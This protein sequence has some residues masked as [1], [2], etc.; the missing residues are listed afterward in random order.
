[1]ATITK[2]DNYSF[3]HC[4]KFVDYTNKTEGTILM[5]GN[6]SIEGFDCGKI[7]KSIYMVEGNYAYGKNG[8][9][10]ELLNMQEDYQQFI[11]AF[12]KT[13][14]QMVP[15]SHIYGN[16]RNGYFLRVGAGFTR[17]I[18]S[19]DRNILTTEGGYEYFVYW[20]C[21]Y[22][23]KEKKVSNGKMQKYWLEIKYPEEFEKIDDERM[24]PILFKDI[25]ASETV[26]FA[27]KV[28]KH[29]KKIFER[30]YETFYKKF[31]FKNKYFEEYK[32][33]PLV[34]KGK[35]LK[36]VFL[37]VKLESVYFKESGF[38]TKCNF[39]YEGKP[40]HYTIGGKGKLVENEFSNF[41]YVRKLIDRYNI[42]KE[43]GNIREFVDGVATRVIIDDGRRFFI[44]YEL[45]KMD[46]D[47][48]EYL[49]A[50]EENLS[51]ISSFSIEGSI[52]DGYYIVGRNERGE[53][54]NEKIVFQDGNI[55]VLEGGSMHFVKWAVNNFQDYASKYTEFWV[56]R[57][58]T[59]MISDDDFEAVAG[60]LCRPILF[61]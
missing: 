5:K 1:M 49:L 12:R 52:R 33:R 48:K 56:T 17:K 59:D 2:V 61:K 51:M 23:L 53:R 18:I 27:E 31:E 30:S 4:G 10:Y 57:L 8:E 14:V 36:D 16:L 47:Y 22:Y 42:L 3:Y 11:E 50:K 15:S 29:K 41:K 39:I 24:R 35:K 37:K 26:E 38:A 21:E 58:G 28:E 54:F 7:I 40:R 32:S 34:I 45:G 44:E 25:K 60:K 46:E 43:T 6:E 55:I 19:Q 20:N 13:W 9:V